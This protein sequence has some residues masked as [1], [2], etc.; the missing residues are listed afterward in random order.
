MDIMM[1]IVVCEFWLRSLFDGYWAG[2]SCVWVLFVSIFFD[3]Y[4]DVGIWVWEVCLMYI[5]M[6]IVDCD[7]D[8]WGDYRLWWVSLMD[9]VIVIVVC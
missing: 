5:V 3:G 6:V 9:I 1:V 7:G 8:S 4:C 2:D